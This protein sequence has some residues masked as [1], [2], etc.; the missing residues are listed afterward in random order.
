M[1]DDPDI[2][3]RAII[4]MGQHEQLLG[5]S[6][7]LNDA[8]RPRINLKAYDKRLLAIVH[9]TSLGNPALQHLVSRIRPAESPVAAV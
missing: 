2:A 3:H 7:E 1:R 6:R 4:E 5:V 8:P 9:Q